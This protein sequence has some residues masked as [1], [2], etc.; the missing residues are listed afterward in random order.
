MK[1]IPDEIFDK[2]IENITNE[3]SVSYHLVLES[4]Y[5]NYEIGFFASE[6]DN[7]QLQYDDFGRMRKNKWEQLEPTERQ[8]KI[9][10]HLMNKER[11]YQNTVDSLNNTFQA[12]DYYKEC[13]VKP[14]DFIQ[15]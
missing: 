2:L 7:Y 15:I 4:K 11:L 9:I 3:N 1:T 10:Q 5:A 14:S 13:G 8:I 12:I 6:D